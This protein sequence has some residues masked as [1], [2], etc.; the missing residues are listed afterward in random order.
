MSASGVLNAISPFVLL[1][2][3]FVYLTVISLWAGTALLL[4]VLLK[5][6]ASTSGNIQSVISAHIVGKSRGIIRSLGFIA[7]LVSVLL[8][9]YVYGLGGLS[10]SYFSFSLDAVITVLS[11]II[12]DE[13]LLTPVS[14]RF[15]SLSSYLDKRNVSEEPIHSLAMVREIRRFCAY[16]IIPALFILLSISAQFSIH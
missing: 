6:V 11:Y 14:S 10:F 13:F 16:Q 5:P 4:F 12:I 3:K 1:L 7:S 2:G 8:I 15:S 9:I